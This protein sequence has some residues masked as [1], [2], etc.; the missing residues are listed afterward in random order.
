VVVDQDGK[1]MQTN[2][3]TERLFGY[4]RE[5]LL[6]WQLQRQLSRWEQVR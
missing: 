5:E 2:A 1:I 4:G 6:G 3:Q